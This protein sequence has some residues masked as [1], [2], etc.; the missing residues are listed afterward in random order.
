MRSPVHARLAC[1]IRRESVQIS[2]ALNSPL[3]P[4]HRSAI[5]LSSSSATTH[6]SCSVQG[7]ID[8]MADYFSSQAPA[9]R[10]ATQPGHVVAACTLVLASRRVT[11]LL[12]SRSRRPRA[13]SWTWLCA[14][15]SPS[16]A[17]GRLS[18]ELFH[19]QCRCRPTSVSGA[20]AANITA[21][22]LLHPYAHAPLHSRL[23]VP[24]S[25]PNITHTLCESSSVC[26][27][28]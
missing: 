22:T 11:S 9:L 15:A 21:I 28:S 19:P 2:F 14:P 5:V 13:P 26:S 23:A 24:I 7:L 16:Q 20:P 10:K 25:P 27:W 1:K 8:A 17:S 12:R 6:Q 4:F 3:H 18:R